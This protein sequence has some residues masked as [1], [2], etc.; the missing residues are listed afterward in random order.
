MRGSN[1]VPLNLTG[2]EANEQVVEPAGSSMQLDVKRTDIH[3][4]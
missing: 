1:Q 2:K 4:A 3:A